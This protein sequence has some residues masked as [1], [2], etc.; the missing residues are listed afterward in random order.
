MGNESKALREEFGNRQITCPVYD[1][2]GNGKV[3]RLIRTINE[4]LRANPELLVERQNKLFYQLVSALRVNK[5]KDGK[6]PFERHTGKRPNTITSIIVKL[7]KELIKLDFDKSIQL[8]K[9]EEFPR[10]DDSTIFVKERQQSE[11]MLAFL[12]EETGRSPLKR[13]IQ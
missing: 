13:G 9:L 11:S 10:D 12:N 6:S 2:R 3:E 7:Y 4:R 1:H 5:G 8:D